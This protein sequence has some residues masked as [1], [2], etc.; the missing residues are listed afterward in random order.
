PSVHTV[1][2]KPGQSERELAARVEAA[3]G[4]KPR[5]ALECTGYQSS[6]R[7]AI[8]SV[9][10]G[11]KVFVIGCGEDEQMF[12]FAYMC[13]NEIDLQFEFRYANQYPKAISLVSRG[14]INV[15]PLVTH[16]LPLEKAIEAFHTTADPA[17]G[18]IKVQIL[19][20]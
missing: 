8:F 4:Q 18:S 10:F 12:P 7:S 15:K 20:L 3:L 16:R 5:V 1:H 9:K 19:D 2:I 11:G 13:A 17:S 6:V 14:L